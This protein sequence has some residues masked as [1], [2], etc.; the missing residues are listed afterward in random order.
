MKE[1]IALAISEASQIGEARRQ[2]TAMARGL[3]FND[4][5]TGKVALLVTEMAT[6]LVRHTPGG[7]VVLRSLGPLPAGG[8]EVLSLDQGPGMT[9]VD[10]C[11]RDGFS[12]AGTAGNG[13]GAIRRLA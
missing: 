2:A 5:E 4:T 1:T 9:N 8:I 12:N 7:E 10:Q 13:L 3:G 6:N 11:L